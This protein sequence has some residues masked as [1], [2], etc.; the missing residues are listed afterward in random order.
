MKPY[1]VILMVISLVLS[2][3]WAMAANQ[4]TLELGE[5]LFHMPNLGG[6]TNSLSCSSCHAKGLLLQ[7]AAKH[8]NLMSAIRHCLIKELG[9]SNKKGRSFSMFSLKSYILSI[10]AEAPVL[11]HPPPDMTNGYRPGGPQQSDSLGQKTPKNSNYKEVKV[12]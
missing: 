6:S 4:K 12:K 11:K 7:E 9:G 2:A 8:S 5:V 10:S 1:P 3:S